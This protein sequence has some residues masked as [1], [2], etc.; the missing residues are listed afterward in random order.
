MNQLSIHTSSPH[1]TLLLVSLVAQCFT[2]FTSLLLILSRLVLGRL[3]K[4][5]FVEKKASYC[6]WKLD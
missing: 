2:V 6:G 1:L 4:S 3:I 5:F